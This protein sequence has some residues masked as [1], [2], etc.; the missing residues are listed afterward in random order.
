M[1]VSPRPKCLV[2]AGTSEARALASRLAAISEIETIASLAGVTSQPT[3]YP[4]T[5]RSGGFGGRD[6]FAAYVAQ[7]KIVAIVN[8]THPFAQNMSATAAHVARQLGVPLLRLLRPPWAQQAGDDWQS[9]ERLSDIR[10]ALPLRASVFL[11]TGSGRFAWV[12]ELATDRKDLTL[13]LRMAEPPP[14]QTEVPENLTCVVARPPFTLEDE[15]AFFRAIEPAI[16]VTKNAGGPSGAV[17]LEVAR[18]RRIRVMMIER[19]PIMNG[20]DMATTVGEAE[21]WVRSR[22]T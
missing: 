21:H 6:G 5:T 11:A 10:L 4:V 13:T 17:K 22:L 15:E 20:V 8:A 14:P 3:A 12:L 19:P 7:E 18:A 1:S 9:F 2:L 16:L